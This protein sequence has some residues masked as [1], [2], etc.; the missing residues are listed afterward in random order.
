MPS[1]STQQHREA[2]A[3][4][5]PVACAILTVSDTRTP[6]TDTSGAAIRERLEA[7]GHRVVF[8]EVVKDEPEQILALLERIIEET[9]ARVVL[10]NGGTG[11]AHRDTTFDAL[12]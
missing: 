4:R 9:E 2:A 5:G 3:E 8:Y 10:L 6:E 7:R 12:S 11:I 1:E